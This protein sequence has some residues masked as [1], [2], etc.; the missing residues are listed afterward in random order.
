VIATVPDSSIDARTLPCSNGWWPVRQGPVQ[1]PLLIRSEVECVA[2][3]GVTPEGRWLGPP[4]AS[5]AMPADNI[6]ASR[7]WPQDRQS[8]LLTPPTP[9]NLPMASTQA[10]RVGTRC[11]VQKQKLENRRRE[12]A[13][14]LALML[15][16]DR[17][18]TSPG[19]HAE[20]RLTAPAPWMGAAI[21]PALRRAG[22]VQSLG[23]RQLGGLEKAFLGPI[24]KLR[25]GSPDSAAA[26]PSSCSINGASTEETAPGPR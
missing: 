8:T 3:L 14:S 17:D 10:R 20:P 22:A 7:G 12:N 1:G 5:P 9:L 18:R 11:L 24:T 21:G 23:S 25:Q 4:K 16:K 19:R 13:L 6:P 2:K 15:A 26:R